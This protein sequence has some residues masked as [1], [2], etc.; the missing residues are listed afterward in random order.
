[1]SIS[2]NANFELLSA[3][4]YLDARQQFNT[5]IEMKDFAETSIPD[6][7]ITYNKETQKHYVFNSSNT[8]DATLGKWREYNSGDSSSTTY[9][10]WDSNVDY[11]VGNVVLK[12]EV[13]YSCIADH[14]STDFET[15]S[16]NWIVI[17][18]QYYHV[19]QEQYNK[20]VS[21]GLITDSTKDLYIID[22]NSEGGNSSSANYTSL[23]ALGLTAPV[24]VGEI[25]NA[26]PDNTMAVL[27]CEAKDETEGTVNI[28]DIPESFGV[29]TIK[30]NGNGRFSI[31]YQN[32]LGSSP[33][34][35][36]RW[37]GTLKGV[38]GTGLYWKQLSTQTTYNTLSDL[39]L[40]TDATIN[41]IVTAMKDGTTFTYKT[42]VFDYAT[43]YNN[44]QYATVTIY[45]QSTGMVQALM[46]DKNTGNLYV[47][48]MDANNLFV[49]WRSSTFHRIVTQATAGYFKFKPTTDGGFEQPL[50]ISV[51]DNYGG[52]IEISGNAPSQSQYKP[53]KCVRLSHG[54][55][56]D[57]NA[58]N[59]INNKMEKLFYFD[60]Y[61]YLK[62]SSY[63]TATFTGL[64]GVPTFVETIDATAEEI[65]IVSV[66]ATQY[67]GYGDPYIVTIGDS[68]SGDGAIQTLASLGLSTDI[69]TWK[70][71]I[72]KV[73]HVSGLTGL[74]SDI[75]NTSPGFRLEHHNIKKWNSNHNPNYQTW[76]QRH[77]VFYA[78]NGNIYHRYYESGATAGTYI[79]DTGWN[80][81]QTGNTKATLVTNTSTLKLD[82]TKKNASW[83]GAIKLT[84]LYD[85][86]LA[87]I[88]IS[89]RSASDNLRWTH[90]NGQKYINNITFTQ[91]SSNTAHYTI[92][93][94]FNGTTYGN[95]QAEVIGDFA[96]INSLT[97]ESFTGANTAIYNAP[98][99][100][101]NGVSLVS[102]PE[103]LGLTYPCTS[104]QLAQAMRNKFNVG[105]KC[106]A[107]GLFN[108]EGKASTITDAPS[109]YGLL[110]VETFGH[111]RIL[112]RFDGIG[113]SSYDGSWIGQIKGSNGTFSSITWLK[114]DNNTYSTTEQPIGTW[115]DGKT[116][117]RKVIQYT[118]ASN[119][120]G[121]E[122]Q[123]TIGSV[124]GLDT[125]IKAEATI[126]RLDVKYD[127]H[128]PY[129]KNVQNHG[130]IVAN[131]TGGSIILYDSS[132]SVNDKLYAII[133]YT[134]Q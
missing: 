43:E 57:Y 87:E 61:M 37:I 93:I 20:M 99:G 29:L 62:I 133:E 105:V 31:D 46:T 103:D 1:M 64:V 84:Y 117:Y 121:I 108:C 21:D 131:T 67:D 22:G 27:A 94:E 96:D 112:I 15:D 39:G 41:D 28:S 100:K 7:F 45:K 3:G 11:K 126:K 16:I 101:N 95:Y 106:G 53:F 60:G 104:V 68:V 79:K 82:V 5:I 78:D 110:H 24:S 32:S 58:S 47:G 123:T 42:D 49:G 76:G 40:T 114:I 107:I 81:I 90:I 124:D 12:D 34:N 50:R 63:T 91:D 115:I 17:L 89:F 33:C 134:K 48:R 23:E 14:T 116:I 102:S 80:K 118:F 59:P 92:G 26:M 6:G 55:Y 75:T 18:E 98:W 38:D 73:S 13:R 56:T 4:L 132:H 8:V 109:N 120:T 128:I 54:T 86:S 71:G 2:L 35:V 69:M 119:A 19:T 72:Y 130:Y 44:L 66:I 88:E 36:K 10:T 111:D 85:I 70:N 30:R 51:T 113:N 83:Y 97:S 129:G 65:P 9:A 127:Y 25:F 125:L 77:S 74:P 52:M 122:T